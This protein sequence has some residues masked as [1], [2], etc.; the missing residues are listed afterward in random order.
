MQKVNNFNYRLNLALYQNR[1]AEKD[2]TVDLVVAVD[3][4]NKAIA[5]VGTSSVYDVYANAL[6]LP[7]E[8]YNLSANKMQLNAGNTKSEE[9]ELNVYSSQLIALVQEEY[10]KDMKFVLPVRIQNSTSYAING[11]T[12]TIM[13]FF[14]VTYVDPGPE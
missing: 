4:L 7:E 5:N 13:F 9:V 8:Y 12:N 3:S 14:N 1:E 2:A 11:K 6:L 10:K